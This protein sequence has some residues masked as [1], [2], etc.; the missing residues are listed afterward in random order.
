MCLDMTREVVK[1]IVDTPVG[2][3]PAFFAFWRLADAA[4][5]L[6]SSPSISL[7]VATVRMLYVAIH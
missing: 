7:R 6:T 5:R 4:L 3:T 2:L 1:R